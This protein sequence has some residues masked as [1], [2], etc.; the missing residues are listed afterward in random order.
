VDTS[1]ALD[2]LEAAIERHVAVAGADSELEAMAG[3]L[4]GALEPAIHQIALGLAE[5]AAAEVSAQLSGHDVDVVL[6]DGEPT[7]R[8]RASSD[9]A[10]ITSESLDA[11]IT[12]RLPPTLKERIEAAAGDVGDSVNAW[13][14]KAVSAQAQDRPGRGTRRIS[15][16]IET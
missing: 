8:V 10:D 16:V 15:G 1:I 14:V 7:L 12:L 6:S 4:M 3:A 2:R 13:L 11:R 5:Q 9:D